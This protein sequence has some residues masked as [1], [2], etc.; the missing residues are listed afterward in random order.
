M[1]G[2]EEA[3]GY[4][5][6]WKLYIAVGCGGAGRGAPIAS[7]NVSSASEVSSPVNALSPSSSRQPCPWFPAHRSWEA[8]AFPG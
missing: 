6:S 4:K 7:L 1:E 8:F 2:R 5:Q 3:H